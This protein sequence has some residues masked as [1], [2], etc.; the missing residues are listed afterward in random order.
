MQLIFGTCIQDIRF[1]DA[2]FHLVA[3][4]LAFLTGEIILNLN[5][6]IPSSFE[7]S[8]NWCTC[9][10]CL[11]PNCWLRKAIYMDKNRD[12]D[13]GCFTR[14]DLVCKAEHWGLPCRQQG[15]HSPELTFKPFLYAP[16]PLIRTCICPWLPNVL[17]D[18]KGSS[19]F[20]SHPDCG[21]L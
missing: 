7:S 11:H 16:P 5:S 13:I 4:D 9:F 17:S 8:A 18:D 20:R 10:P 15:A 3:F 12:R 6:L 2:K 14:G 21:V 1:I 19:P